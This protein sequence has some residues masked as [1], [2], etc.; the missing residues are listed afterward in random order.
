V[1]LGPASGS[2]DE[3]QVDDPLSQ[4]K[5]SQHPSEEQ[6]CPWEAQ[7]APADASCPPLPPHEPPEHTSPAQHGVLSSQA[8][9]VP[10]QAPWLDAPQLPL[11]QLIPPQQS[12]SCEHAP[13]LHPQLPLTHRPEQHDAGSVQPRPS[14][15]QPPPAPGAWASLPLAAPLLGAQPPLWQLMPLQQSPSPVHV[16]PFCEHPQYALTHAPVQQSLA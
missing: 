15:W 2:P 11:W 9:L 1:Q 6:S 7:P 5:P 14:C 8:A 3:T 4:S 12:P 16:P 13:L 10:P